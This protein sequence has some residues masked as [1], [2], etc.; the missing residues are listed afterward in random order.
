M[1]VWCLVSAGRHPGDSGVMVILLRLC[2]Y[3][4]A[5]LL[6]FVLFSLG[7]GMFT[8]WNRTMEKIAH[9]EG[10]GFAVH[11]NATDGVA[12]PTVPGSCQLSVVLAASLRL[13]LAG[14]QCCLSQARAVPLAA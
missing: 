8:G 4:R 9:M 12:F 7:R 10:N 1:G 5:G 14:F 3:V 6:V 2:I 11:R 13:A